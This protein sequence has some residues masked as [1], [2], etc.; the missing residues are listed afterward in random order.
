MAERE[1]DELVGNDPVKP[2][3][4]LARPWPIR[5][6]FSFHSVPARPLST[7]ALDAVSRKLTSV[8]ISAGSTSA[9]KVCAGSR[10]GQ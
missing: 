6:W 3:A 9:L 8:I 5:S 1:N 2:E 7:L 10:P 4:S